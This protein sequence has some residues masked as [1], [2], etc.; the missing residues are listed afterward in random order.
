MKTSS[1]FGWPALEI[2]RAQEQIRPS[3]DPELPKRFARIFAGPDGEAALRHLR[4][5]TLE[6]HLGPEA[7][8]ALLRHLEGQRHLVNHIQALIARG[9]QG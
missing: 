7:G 4:A 8:V 6:R 1:E 3:F 5:I 2:E 9:R